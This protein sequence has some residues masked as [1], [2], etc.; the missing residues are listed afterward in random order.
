MNDNNLII[1]NYNYFYHH[2]NLFLLFVEHWGLSAVAQKKKYFFSS[3]KIT[4]KHGFLEEKAGYNVY[5]H[6]LKIRLQEQLKQI[7]FRNR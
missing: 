1:N 7:R 2:Q 4:V 3:G 6:Q 5:I